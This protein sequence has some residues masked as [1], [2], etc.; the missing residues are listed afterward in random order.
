MIIEAQGILN[1]EVEMVNFDGKEFWDEASE[2]KI[3]LID[4]S[5]QITYSHEQN[6]FK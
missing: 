2:K 3:S 5:N 1:I 4:L 6:N